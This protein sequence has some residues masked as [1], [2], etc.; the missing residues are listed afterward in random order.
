[1][2]LVDHA[3]DLALNAMRVVYRRTPLSAVLRKLLREDRGVVESRHVE[4]LTNRPYRIFTR[5][6]HDAGRAAPVLFALHAYS[7]TSDIVLDG[8]RLRSCAVFRRGWV[9]VVPEGTRDATGNP[10][11]NATAGYSGRGPRTV[12][13][14][15]Y[16]RAVLTQV[17]AR[18]AIE[19]ARVYAVGVSNGAFM[20]VRWAAES[21]GDLRGIACL[22]G[23]G[24]GPDDPPYSPTV[25][26]RVLQIHGTEDDEVLFDGGRGPN[27]AYPSVLET[28]TAWRSICSAHD[29]PRSERRRSFVQGPT[30]RQTWRGERGDVALWI[31]EGGGHHLYGVRWMMDDVLDFL[32]GVPER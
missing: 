7:S 16:L 28:N 27:G 21:G 26:V 25:P 1:M 11:W 3:L 32:D 4:P 30:H 6:D 13:D 9:L 29:P 19:P 8:L 20:A 22:S 2:P 31:V 14:L 5:A 15:G 23:G 10:F 18:F 17:R 24:L 12:D